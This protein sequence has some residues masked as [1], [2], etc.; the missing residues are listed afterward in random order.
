MRV[1][2]NQ[3]EFLAAEIRKY[4]SDCK[5]FLF[6]SRTDDCQKGGDIDIAVI[7]ARKLKH[8]E[9]LKIKRAF[10]NKH[11]EQK[12]DL[13]SFT[14]TEKSNFLELIKETKMIEI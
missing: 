10:Y 6:G 13:L 11:G 4:L 3:M 5:I 14:E 8:I 7:G 2:N 9:K 12:L 1:K